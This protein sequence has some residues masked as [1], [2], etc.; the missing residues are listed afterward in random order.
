MAL[1]LIG[2]SVGFVVSATIL[3]FAMF[4]FYPRLNLTYLLILG[5]LGFLGILH[6]LAYTAR[7]RLSADDIVAIEYVVLVLGSTS[8]LSV[9]SL[10][11]QQGGRR[12][13]IED[14]RDG[15]KRSRHPI[16]ACRTSILCEPEPN[17]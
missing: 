15:G 5:F 2:Y 3:M 13:S 11:V 12:L 6:V 4:M 16:P 17:V 9:I 10:D 7:K 1:K 14:S 8:L